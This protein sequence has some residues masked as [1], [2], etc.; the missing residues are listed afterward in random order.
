LRVFRPKNDPDN[1]RFYKRGVTLNFFRILRAYWWNLKDRRWR[2]SV[3]YLW[4]RDIP[5]EVGILLRRA[6]MA[7]HFGKVGENL[8]INPGARFRNP[9]KIEAGNHV[10]IGI[11]CFIQA[12]GGLTLGDYALL[13]PG[14]KI[15]TQ[16]H[17]YD[18]PDTP[19]GNQGVEYHPVEIGRDCWIGANAFIMPGV[20]LP[21]GCVVAAGSVVGIKPYKEFSILVGN[22][23]RVIGFR[24]A[25]K[26]PA[27]DEPVAGAND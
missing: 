17:R 1:K 13:G 3:R 2:V 26:K 22:P 6:V 4:V 10:A 12:G 16:N 11:D 27:A 25:K 5:G 21:R 18:D 20:K 19:V 8:M 14:C 23:A 24:G 9:Q 7:P 15:W